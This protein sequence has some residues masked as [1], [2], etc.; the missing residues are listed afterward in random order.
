M[1]RLKIKKSRL[2]KENSTCEVRLTY[3]Q[4]LDR[5]YGLLQLAEKYDIFKKVS[6]KYEMLDG[7]KVFGK[8]INDN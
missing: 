3:D 6:T 1:L 8:Q 7:K 5:H 2:T 4:G